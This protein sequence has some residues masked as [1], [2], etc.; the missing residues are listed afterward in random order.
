LKID[1]TVEGF[2]PDYMKGTSDTDVT[3]GEMKGRINYPLMEKQLGVKL[4]GDETFDELLEIE[5]NTKETNK[6]SVRYTLK[7]NLVKFLIYKM[8]REWKLQSL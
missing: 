3:A 8:T 4:R 5:K 6:A 7:E 2:D 1:E